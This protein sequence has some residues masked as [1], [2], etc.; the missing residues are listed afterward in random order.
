ML[1]S[2]IDG[3]QVDRSRSEHSSELRR[4]DG[5]LLVEIPDVC[6]ARRLRVVR[7]RSDHAMAT[8]AYILVPLHTKGQLHL[9]TPNGTEMDQL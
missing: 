9:A 1:H 3:H 6:V 8:S 2:L 5:W 7:G 4:T